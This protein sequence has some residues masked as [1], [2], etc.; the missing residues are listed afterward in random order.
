LASRRP[1]AAVSVINDLSTD[2]RVKKNCE[3]LLNSGFDVV[4]IGRRLPTSRPIT[5]RTYLTLRMSLL[6]KTG[7]FFYLFFNLRLFFVLLFRR[8]SLLWANDLDT[9]LPNYLVS[10]IK[11]VPLIYD[12]HE[13]FCEVP[14]LAAHPLKKRIWQALEKFIVPKLKHC[15][16]VSGG[17]AEVFKKKY[18]THFVV[19]RNIPPP[20]PFVN[21]GRE[22]LGLPPGKFLVILQG[23]G[24]NV[25]RGA[26]EL[27]LSMK[28][29]QDTL[30]LV[31]G[32]GDV[33]SRL[34][35]LVDDESLSDRVQLIYRMGKD[36]L[37]QYTACCDL[38]VSI[39][40]DNNL[41]YRHSLPN[42]LFDYIQAGIP[43]L[44]SRLPEIEKIVTGYQIGCFIENH[45]PQ[46]IAA[47]IK[48][49][50]GAELQADLRKNILIAKQQLTWQNEEPALRSV[51]NSAIAGR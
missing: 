5:D 47:R 20:T 40:K 36:K 4:L 27:I 50:L 34:K 14:E 9:L 38:G 2:I 10:K 24:I 18:N 29:L 51:I 12:S 15:I 16:T 17:I 28:H 3:A 26:E 44:A 21:V 35:N 30:L 19:V 46:H 22:A 6:F 48:E 43:V 41:N 42:K 11:K 49:M 8:T 7:P 33:W 37:M 31:I 25:D 45:D 32:S 39:D 13:L 1:I 23:A